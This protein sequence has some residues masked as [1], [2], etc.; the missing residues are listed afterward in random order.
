MYLC[1]CMYVCNYLSVSPS[2][3]LTDLK[4]NMSVILIHVKDINHSLKKIFRLVYKSKLNS[5]KYKLHI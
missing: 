4:P 2:I 3:C 1:V 5:S